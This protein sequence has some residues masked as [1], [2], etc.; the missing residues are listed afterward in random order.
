MNKSE[1]I[2][3]IRN[4]QREVDSLLDTVI[5]MEDSQTE[6]PVIVQQSD[7]DAW[8]T[9]K[10]TCEC[11]KISDSTFYEY[12]RQG[13]LPPGLEFGPR[14][15]RWRMS[16]IRAWQESR[17]HHDE[18]ERPKTTVRRRGRVS[19]VRKVEDFCRV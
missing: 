3:R 1:L 19:R 7:N 2:A 6:Q 10:Q 9:A 15:K 13:L 18:V 16:D 17:K 12:I 11:L 14:S 8:M 4:L 5:A